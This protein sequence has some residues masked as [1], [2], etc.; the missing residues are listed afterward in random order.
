MS[1]DPN[2]STPSSEST[3]WTQEQLPP[4]KPPTTGFLMQLFFVPMLIVAVI[5]GV[6][7]MFGWLA[8]SGTNPKQLAENLRKLNKGSWQD[9][10]SLSDLLRNPREQELRQDAEL[11]ASLA[12]TLQGLLEDPE[13]SVSPERHK[14]AT[15]LCRALGE[16]EVDAGISALKQAVAC[17]DF[18]IRKSAVEGIT[19]L[20]ANLPGQLNSAELVPLLR[21]G[22][23]ERAP[24]ADRQDE[25]MYGETRS[26]IAYC[27]GV[28]GGEEAMVT[29]A[30]MLGDPY[31]GAR[32]NAATGLARHGDLRAVDGLI[33]MLQPENEDATKYEAENA[34]SLR[35]WKRK[36]VIVNG[37][38]GVK[39][40]YTA[41]ETAELAPSILSAVQAVQDAKILRGNDALE[42][43]ELSRW[44]DSRE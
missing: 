19:K 6:W 25:L 14:L 34:T 17:D 30:L 29:L 33:E 23:M 31:A 12:E 35:E 9:A 27:L 4:V 28:L 2:S 3:N 15:W 40:L 36:K 24:S 18:T 21:E 13:L 5:V 39:A 22:A 38:R 42:L 7:V 11:A 32:Y 26:A 37:G 20:S 44:L 10:Y 8:Q 1:A 16:F 41:N 43:D